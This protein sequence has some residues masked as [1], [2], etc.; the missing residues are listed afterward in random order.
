MFTAD[1]IRVVICIS[2]LSAACVFSPASVRGQDD[3]LLPPEMAAETMLVPDGFN[4]TLFAGEPDVMQPIGFC[5]DDRGRLWVAEAYNYPHHGTK[6][7]DRIVILEDT[8]HDGRHDKR[9]VFYDKLN[10]VSGIEVGFGGAWVMSPPYFYFIPDKDGDDRPDGEPQLLLDGFGNHSNAHNMANGFAWGP[11]GWLYGTHGRTNWSMVGVPGSSDDDRV[12]FDGGVYRY[13][14]VRHIWEP[15]ADGATNPWGIDWDDY[16]QSFICNCVNPHLFHV[17][18]GAHYE[19]WRNRKSSEFAYKR[20]PTIADH[21]HFTGTGNVRDGIG[22]GAEDSAGGGH[23]HCGT[24]IYLG[25]NWPDRY[26]N[27]LFTNNIHGRRINNDI[28]KRSGSGYV[29]SHG[30]D[31]MRSRDPWFMGVTLAYGPD[32]SVFVSDWSD[33]GECH[34][35][36]NTRRHTGR[37]YRIAYGTPEK[38][39]VD[40]TQLSNTEL[41]QLQTHRNDWFVRHA[42][43]V[44]QERT[45]AGEDMSAV[46]ELLRAVFAHT[47]DV[48][49]KLRCLWALHVTEGLSRGDLLEHLNDESEHVRTWAV[50]LLVESPRRGP[51]YVPHVVKDIAKIGQ[52]ESETLKGLVGLAA[53]DPSALVRLYLASALQRIPAEQRWA[54]A[55]ALLQ[56]SEDAD[57]PNLPLMNWYAIEPLVHVDLKRFV[58][59]ASTSQLPLVRNHVARRVSSLKSKGE[60][61]ALL[62]ELLSEVEDAPVQRDIVDGM[63]AGLTGV[64]SVSMPESWPAAYARLQASEDGDVRA[65]AIRLAVLFNDLDAIRGLWTQMTN[66]A[67]TAG[68]RTRAIDALVAIQARDLAPVL[69]ELVTDPDVQTSAIRGLAEYDHAETAAALLKAYSSL[70]AAARTNVVQTLASRR[71][72]ATELLSG[73]QSGVVP[74]SDISAFTA[75][76]IR[77]LGEESLTKRLTEVW[78]DVRATP[79]D[80]ARQIEAYR[81][82]LTSDEL[83]HADLGA[84]RVVF[85][86]LCANC[87]QL[88]D[89]GRKVGPDLTGAQRGSLDYLLENLID[90]NAQIARD[91]QMEV[92]V[93]ESGRTVTGLVKSETDAAL[94]IATLNADVVIPVG[95]ITV[96]KKSDVSLMPEG[97]LKTLTY[98][99]TRDLIGYLQT[100]RQVPLPQ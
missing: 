77:N 33:T 54:I 17:I 20:I 32:G 69:L 83:S 44:L 45:A 58:D 21:L 56:H 14:P 75:R 66:P 34:S 49:R 23:A 99:Q 68:D 90:P 78:G 72:W 27:S 82:R 65:A 36:R 22:S 10:Y 57:D 38:R 91:Y 15:Y 47:D 86:K 43:R 85:Q 96:R 61:L 55:D 42:R 93:T 84:G 28:L 3:E 98:E 50:Q 26:R 41:V 51:G 39:D 19:P 81:K 92:I 37:V 16:G 79:K 46:H 52:S 76:Q 64:R 24:M 48:P 100:V 4:V 70:P 11:D 7:G 30:P 80:R 73:V 18:P 71:E 12:R 63:L 35:V 53:D 5:I 67:A 74:R 59:L 94:T 40:V 2:A 87:H 25:D 9:T 60:G 1:S 13:H 89:S 88:F 62:A 95:E 31:I 6:P 29:A 8:D 97:Q